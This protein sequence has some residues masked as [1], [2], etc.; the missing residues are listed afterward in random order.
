MN[1]HVYCKEKKAYI[2]I[3]E[4]IKKYEDMCVFDLVDLERKSQHHLLG[5]E[6]KEMYGFNIDPKIV[7]S[8]DYIN[9]GRYMNLCQWGEGTSREISWSDNGEQPGN[10]LLLSIS[11][12]TGAYIF[13]DDYP[14]DLFSQ[15]FSELKSYNPKYLDT[16]NKSLYFS[17]DN[18]GI[19]FNKFKSILEKY[20]KLNK[21]DFKK[22]K[23]KRMKDELEKLETKT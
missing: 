17:L 12:P 16:A 10:E 14:K 13:G 20:Y 6:L 11:F 9:F 3:F 8:L 4:L 5:I 18:A 22:R 1:E 21:E 2:E 23:I 15:F 19:I 7:H